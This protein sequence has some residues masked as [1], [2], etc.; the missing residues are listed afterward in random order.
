M[1]N[2]HYTHTVI[3]KPIIY[4][5]STVHTIAIHLVRPF[6]LLYRRI[7]SFLSVFLSFFCTRSLASVW[8]NQGNACMRVQHCNM[9]LN[10]NIKRTSCAL[11]NKDTY[12]PQKK[13]KKKK[14]KSKEICNTLCMNTY[15]MHQLTT[16]FQRS[17]ICS[18]R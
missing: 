2:E 10:I 3:L 5:M 17:H 8:R 1:A 11:K 13:K 14:K 18:S 15:L 7:H 9:L 16:T 6:A 12:T 4:E